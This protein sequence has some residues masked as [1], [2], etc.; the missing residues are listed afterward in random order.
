MYNIIQLSRHIRFA[1]RSLY[2]HYTAF[3][4]LITD[5]VVFHLGNGYVIVYSI[6]LPLC[7]LSSRCRRIGEPLAVSL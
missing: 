1:C 3:A 5:R 6:R 7:M 4:S 2:Q